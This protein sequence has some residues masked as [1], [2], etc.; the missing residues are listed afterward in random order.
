FKPDFF[1]VRV[2]NS[3]LFNKYQPAGALQG[4]PPNQNLGGLITATLDDAMEDHRFTGGFRLPINLSGSTYFLQYENFKRRVDWGILFYR[5]V[6]T[7]NYGVT[8]VDT[9]TGQQFTAPGT[10]TGKL[11]SN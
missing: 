3:I 7:Y 8:L 2:D 10:Y 6:N 5:D 11:A 1:T 4:L 9:S